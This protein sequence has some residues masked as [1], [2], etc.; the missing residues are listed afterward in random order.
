[1]AQAKPVPRPS[2]ETPTVRK[3]MQIFSSA[4][5][6]QMWKQKPQEKQQASAARSTQQ[7]T[8][9]ARARRKKDIGHR[10]KQGQAEASAN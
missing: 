2:R 5:Q 8:G 1:M 6:L 10:I 7:A 4:R 9:Q 3:R